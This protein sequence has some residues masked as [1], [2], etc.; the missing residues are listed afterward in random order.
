MT[1]VQNQL[2]N[3]LIASFTQAGDL[4]NSNQTNIQYLISIGH[5]EE[6]K[7]AGYHLVPHRL[8]LEFDDIPLP[9]SGYTP[10]GRKDVEKIISFGTSAGVSG[11]GDLLIHCGAGI[12]RSTAAALGIFAASLKPQAAL[13]R[14]ILIQPE[15][16]PNRMM[17]RFADEILGCN[18]KLIEVTDNYIQSKLNKLRI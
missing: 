17:V 13:L 4:L 12:S 5:P 15:A 3:I 11:E 14:V 2:P 16:L 18:G 9:I 1:N 7:P 10:P 8:R 6:S